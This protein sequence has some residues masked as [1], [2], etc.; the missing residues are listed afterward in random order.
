[1]RKE[2]AI[3]RTRRRRMQ[4]KLKLTSKPSSRERRTDHHRIKEIPLPVLPSA[5][6][7]LGVTWRPYTSRCF[8]TDSTYP[9]YN[10]FSPYSP[11]QLHRRAAPTRSTMTAER[12]TFSAN[13]SLVSNASF[14]HQSSF[15]SG[16]C[17]STAPPPPHP[18]CHPILSSPA[19]SPRRKKVGEHRVALRLHVEQLRSRVKLFLASATGTP[20]QEKWQ[21]PKHI[22]TQRRGSSVRTLVRTFPTF[23]HSHHMG[24]SI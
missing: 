16:A 18:L 24:N 9:N 17:A 5:E 2:R 14:V 20:P 13:S 4:L 22:G 11:F 15:I 8:G 21:I 1:M 23:A 12:C 10:A 3:R 6:L 19:N 7:T